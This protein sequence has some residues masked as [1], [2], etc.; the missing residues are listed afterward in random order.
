VKKI[1]GL[2]KMQPF[3]EVWRNFTKFV[4][5][6]ISIWQTLADEAFHSKVFRCEKLDFI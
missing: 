4:F 2:V 5:F 3:P 6:S 1:N